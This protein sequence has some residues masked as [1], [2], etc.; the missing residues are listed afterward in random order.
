M[1]AEQ[2]RRFAAAATADPAARQE[3]FALLWREYLPRAEVYL[4][5]FAALPAEDREELASDAVLRAFAA[6]GRYD[7]ERAFAPWFFALLRRLACDRLA[8]LRRRPLDAGGEAVAAAP[9]ESR[10]GPEADCEAAER[11]AFVDAFLAA[12]PER[13][14][15]LAY[16]VHGEGLTLAEAARVT[17]E[18]L[19][20]VTW[21][22]SV[23][24]R[25]LRVAYGR[26]YG[27]N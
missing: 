2:R 16:L 27:E 11:R 1:D 8:A 20:T 10:A 13:S 19:G 17:G 25:S 15:E 21:R 26:E 18:P 14:R 7:P 9:D 22:M 4:R 6:A 23:L 24:R 12:A 3:V 5:S